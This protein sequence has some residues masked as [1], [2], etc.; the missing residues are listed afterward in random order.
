MTFAWIITLVIAVYLVVGLG[1]AAWFTL[2]GN[3]RV[4]PALREASVWL[5]L[6]M[7]PGAVL[8]WPLLWRRMVGR[9]QASGYPPRTQQRY[10]GFVWMLL[11]VILPLLFVA[12]VRAFPDPPLSANLPTLQRPA[13]PSAEGQA[14]E[15]LASWRRGHLLALGDS[16]QLAVWIGAI[17]SPDPVWYVNDQAIGP[18]GPRGWYR[19]TLWER[20]QSWSILDGMNGDTLL[21]QFIPE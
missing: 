10:A 14:P 4:L 17:A 11:A 1:F 9:G 19:H 8:L 7:V 12:A 6:L 5:R 18:V 20:P 2:R 13:W 21:H 16:M 3:H 15:T